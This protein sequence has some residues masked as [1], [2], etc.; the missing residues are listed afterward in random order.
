MGLIPSQDAI[1]SLLLQWVTADILTIS[2]YNQPPMS[3]Q[4][5]IPPG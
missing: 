3:T 5:S 4:S 1:K 2:V